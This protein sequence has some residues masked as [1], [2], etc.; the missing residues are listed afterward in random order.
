MCGIAGLFNSKGVPADLELLRKMAEKL[1]NRGPDGEGFFTDGIFGLAHRRLSII[2]LSGGAQPLFN[3]DR[4]IIYV[5]NGEIYN[6]HELRAELESKG[7]VFRTRSDSE[8]IGHLYEEYGMDFPEKLEGMFAIA[9]LDLKKRKLI[10]VTDRAGKKPIFYYSGPKGFRFASTLTALAQD[11]DMPEDFDLQAIWDYMSFLTIPAPD[12]LYLGVGKM[13]PACIMAVSP[14]MEYPDA[15]I[16]WKPDYSRRNNLD[17]GVC[18]AELRNVLTKAV[19]SRM[20]ADVPLGVFLS[21]GLDSAVIAAIAS[22][23]PSRQPL[24]CFSIGVNDPLY[25]ESAA[26]KR[27]AA[28][29]EARA[30]RPVNFHQ[31]KIV[32]EDFDL[33]RKLCAEYGEPFADASVLPTHLLCRFA[34]ETVTVALSGDGADELFAGYE[35]YRALKL[36]ARFDSIPAWIRKPTLYLTRNFGKSC[37][38]RTFPGRVRRFLDVAGV[39]VESQYHAMTSKSTL[40]LKKNLMGAAY[41]DFTPQP[42]RRF[43]T[44]LRKTSTAYG[45]TERAMEFDW[46]FYLANDILT[47]MDTASMAASME[48]RSPFLDRRVVETAAA[49]PLAYKLDGKIRKLILSEAFR[50]YIPPELGTARK[51]GFGIP[52]A[53]W[54]RGPWKEQ[55]CGSIL[56][57]AAVNRYE[58]FRKDSAEYMIRQHC[59]MRQDFGYPLYLLLVL[60]LT[61][62]GLKRG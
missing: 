60:E 56:E 14:D 18:A 33:L 4:T 30:A 11:P 46:H 6:H 22:R 27:N 50:G 9:L 43:W 15:R 41:S 62:Q 51:K 19:E 52:V 2:D 8:C 10:L 37:G 47:K 5:H 25:D 59:E 53:D 21:G 42:T 38:E 54:L 20:E 39:P 36:L 28:F 44:E 35:R 61:L 55:M 13:L 40:A 58:L 12:T 23:I 16:Y 29:I 3:E 24:D 57:G 17:F 49:I 32:P 31:K 7:H 1:K 34:R 45:R 48:V 26:A